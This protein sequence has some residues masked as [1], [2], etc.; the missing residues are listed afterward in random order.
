MT[1]KLVFIL[2]YLMR[3]PEGLEQRRSEEGVFNHRVKRDNL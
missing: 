1:W 3:N 2:R